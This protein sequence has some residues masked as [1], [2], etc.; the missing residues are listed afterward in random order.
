MGILTGRSGPTPQP[1]PDAP[2]DVIT[3]AAL[4]AVAKLDA[5]MA[6]SLRH[7]S[8]DASLRVLQE[9][10]HSARMILLDATGG[11]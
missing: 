3:N 8:D 2:A 7:T 4:R 1:A 5:G 10:V 11:V 9:H 6:A